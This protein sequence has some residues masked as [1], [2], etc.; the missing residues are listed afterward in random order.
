MRIIRGARLD[1]RLGKPIGA[2]KRGIIS[3]V[4]GGGNR[5]THGTRS[6]KRIERWRERLYG[7]SR[8]AL[9][10]HARKARGRAIT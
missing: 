8:R 10:R 4:I 6:M 5:E 9:V 1:D 3:E 2:S 7:G